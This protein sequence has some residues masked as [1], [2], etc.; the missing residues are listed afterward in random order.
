M[1]FVAELDPGAL[2]MSTLHVL[3]G[4]DLWQRADEVGLVFDPHPPHEV[5]RTGEIT[6]ADLRRLEVMGNAL[7]EHYRARL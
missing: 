7:M 6:F 5:V 3:P 2:Q 1:R 4:T